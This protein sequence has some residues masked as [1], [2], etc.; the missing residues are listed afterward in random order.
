[1]KR[2]HLFLSSAAAAALALGAAGTAGAATITSGHWD[3]GLEYDCSTGQFSSEGLHAHNHDLGEEAE[4]ADT[5][6]AVTGTSNSVWEQTVFGTSSPVKV[7]GDQGTYRV[8]FAVEA[9]GDCTPPSVTFRKVAN[10]S[11][12]SG[13]RVAGYSRGGALASPPTTYFDSSSGTGRNVG[14]TPPSSTGFHE[15][16]RWGFS[17]T[18]TY[19]LSIQARRTSTNAPLDTKT[20]TF[21]VS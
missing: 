15:D 3:I 6:F 17:G 2:K 11:I 7:I 5:T 18:G 8:G 1:M 10:V 19:K 16:P 4:L 13:Q 12:P 9:D 21:G 20:V 14:L